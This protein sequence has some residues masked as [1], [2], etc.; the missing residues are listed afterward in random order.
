VRALAVLGVLVLLAGG[1]AAWA[2]AKD[3]QT[4][5]VAG[6][7]CVQSS[8]PFATAVP[9]VPATVRMNVYN[10][11]QQVGLATRVADELKL[12]GFAVDQI[13]NDPLKQTV[14][15][16]AQIRYGPQGAGAAQLLRAHIPGAETTVVTRSD[17]EIDVVLGM[18]YLHL[19][20]PAEAAQERAKLGAPVP[21]R[22]C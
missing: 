17:A 16:V 1:A 19:A 7:P 6:T 8:V 18:Q 12:R 3:A 2:I 9:T 21:P 10:A 4:A 13:G 5:Q 22:L 15:G 20:T 14:P 11:T